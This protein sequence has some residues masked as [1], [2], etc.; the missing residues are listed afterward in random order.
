MEALA[1]ARVRL[2][3]A[4]TGLYLTDGQEMTVAFRRSCHFDVAPVDPNALTPLCGAHTPTC[5]VHTRTSRANAP[6]STGPHSAAGR[7]V[8]RCNALKHGIFAGRQIML[9]E[10]ADLT[11]P[12]TTS[13]IALQ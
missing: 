7:P 1:A 11:A 5:G 13:S 3:G 10:T 8:S 12:S 9:D 6:K 4:V 2:G